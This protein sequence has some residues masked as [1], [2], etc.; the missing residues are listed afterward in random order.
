M[1]TKTLK[2]NLVKKNL[3]KKIPEAKPLDYSD[4]SEIV[5]PPRMIDQVIGQENAISLIK[6]AAKQK[7]HIM[8][9]GYPGTGKSMVASALAEILPADALKDIVVYPNPEDP[10][11]PIIKEVPAGEGKKIVEQAKISAMKSGSTLKILG[12]IFPLFWLIFSIYLWQAKI[13]SDVIF[14]AL[15]LLSGFLTMGFSLS[16]QMIKKEKLGIPKVLV[17]N[18]NKKQVPFID[19]TGARAGALLGDVLHDP[20][21][22]GGLGTPAH[23]RVIPG[24]IH[25]ANGG[26]LFID[27]IATLSP[28]S[29]QELLTI[30]QEKKYSITGQS[31]RSSGANVRT[32]PAPCDF[33]LVAAGNYKDLERVHPAI[34]S[35]IRGSGYECHMNL[36]VPN[37]VENRNKYVQF[38][39]QEI[40]KDK[41]IPPFKKEAVDEIIFEARMMATRK[42]HLSLKLRE[43]GGLIRAAG[44]VAIEKGLSYVTKKEVIEA[45]KISATLEEQ[46]VKKLMDFKKDY[47]IY[48]TKGYEKGRVNGLAV[49]GE[50]MAGVVLPIECEIT[51]AQSRTHGR[52]VATGKLGTIAKESVSNVS[53]IFKKLTGKDIANYDIHIQFLQTYDVEGDSASISVATAVIS[54]LEGIPI[55]Q[56][57][58]MTGSLS[59]RGEV[60]PIGG[61]TGK[62]N[63]AVDAKIKQ[64]IIPASN[65]ED[66][67]L[68]EEVARKIEIIPVKTIWDVL[69]IALKDCKKKEDLL[70]RV[71]H[72][73]GISLKPSI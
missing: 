62:I 12:F 19:A 52:V 56:D 5:V 20:L 51:P 58:A 61:V 31:E 59:V 6:K 68:H 2:K 48:K 7:R 66:V 65:L 60:L 23:E 69:H 30:I 16:T 29:Q 27:E 22:T 46:M 47:D 26:V 70:K 44:D 9:I 28:E 53:A 10:Q 11:T 38:V 39:A 3:E 8:L 13:V 25:K 63:A 4:T 40:A 18:S 71:K 24:M 17:D 64:V 72:L 49:V 73:N 37:T 57:L 33:I 32:T 21:Q 15:L 36:D 67:V 50:S 1:K 45:K 55:N 14:A 54:V 34:R 42:N 35:R 41:K 43:L